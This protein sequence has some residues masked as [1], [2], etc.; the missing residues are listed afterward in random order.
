MNF[1]IDHEQLSEPFS[2]STPV[3]E[4]IVAEKVYHDYPFSVNHKSIMA[5]LVEL[6]MV[7][8]DVILCMDCLHVCYASVDCRT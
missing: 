7:D 2:V 5:D 4:S 1:D 6:D 8:F 3:G